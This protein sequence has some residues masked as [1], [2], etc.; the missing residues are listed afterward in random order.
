M[1]GAREEGTSPEE[2]VVGIYRRMFFTFGGLSSFL[3]LCSYF[4]STWRR[5]QQRQEEEEEV[6]YLR[7]EQHKRVQLNEWSSN[8]EIRY[9]RYPCGGVRRWI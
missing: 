7:S 5:M 4:L 3:A 2:E 1:P 6:L 9:C 8:L